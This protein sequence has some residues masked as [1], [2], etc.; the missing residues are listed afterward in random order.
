M[1]QKF[2]GRLIKTLGFYAS[3]LNR[4]DA[5]LT[6]KFGINVLNS[7]FTNKTCAFPFEERDRM[8]LRGLVPPVLLTKE[9]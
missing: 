8:G 3:K 6:E 7:P 5:N 2:R 1:M 9:T 4:F